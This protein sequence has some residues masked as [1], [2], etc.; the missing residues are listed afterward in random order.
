MSIF[1]I[2]SG[3]AE[4]LELQE[5]DAAIKNKFPL[6][7]HCKA[8]KRTWFVNSQY[9][10]PKEVFDLLQPPDVQSTFKHRAFIVMPVTAYW[11]IANKYVW[12]WLAAKGV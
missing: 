6:T 3:I 5:I 12:D 10:T 9:G 4:D 11:G 1:V 2:F 8:D 7:D